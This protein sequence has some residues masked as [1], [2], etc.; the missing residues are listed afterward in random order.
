NVELKAADASSNPYLAVG[1]LIAAG[2]DGLERGLEPPDPVEVDPVTIDEHERVERG[3][4]RLPA[5][6]EEA[7]NALEADAVLTD[8]LGPVL[9]YR[10][11]MRELAGFFGCAPT[12]EAVYEYRMATDPA[13]Y[14]SALLRS[15]RTETLLVD[16][17]FPPPGTAVEWAELGELAGCD[18]RPVM[19]I[20]R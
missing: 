7:L 10:R 8:A 3:I 6:Q 9:T 15:T 13:Q 16:D 2:L 20:E 11:A 1:G 17:G 4:V 18:A 14:A 19:R 5:T 12:E